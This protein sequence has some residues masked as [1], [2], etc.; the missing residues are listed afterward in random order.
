[1]KKALKAVRKCEY[2]RD[3]THILRM[4][5]RRCNWLTNNCIVF[6]KSSG[7]LT[8]HTSDFK[9]SPRSPTEIKIYNISHMLSKLRRASSFPCFLCQ[10]VWCDNQPPV[11]TLTIF[12]ISMLKLLFIL[13]FYLL[14]FKFLKLK[15][16][17]VDIWEI[18]FFLPNILLS[19]Q[20]HIYH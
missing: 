7:Y 2:G 1:M 15:C 20:E 6:F 13:Q 17:V 8:H 3:A 14:S 4:T 5:G 11:H 9:D 16:E 12:T 10:W 18:E 19:L